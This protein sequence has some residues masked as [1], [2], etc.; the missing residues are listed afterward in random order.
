EFWRH[1]EPQSAIRQL[2]LLLR[3]PRSEQW[4][5]ASPGGHAETGH[6]QL[7]Y[8]G[9]VQTR[10]EIWQRPVTRIAAAGGE[11]W[12]LPRSVRSGLTDGADT[13]TVAPAARPLPESA[14]RVARGVAESR[15]P[16]Y[17]RPGVDA[18]VDTQLGQVPF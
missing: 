8:A 4:L 6:S 9:W 18:T 12:R 11:K 2:R 16:I 5:A 13:P 15:I 10:P 14:G 3:H 1:I 7:T 17:C